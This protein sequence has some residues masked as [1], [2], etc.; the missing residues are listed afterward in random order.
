VPAVLKMAN[1]AADAKSKAIKA[2]NFVIEN[3]AKTMKVA[4]KASRPVKNNNL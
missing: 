3:L 2:R 4:E 1:N